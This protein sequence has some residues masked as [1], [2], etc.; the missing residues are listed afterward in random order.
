[1]GKWVILISAMILQVSV[2]GCSRDPAI[3]QNTGAKID[4]TLPKPET[5]SQAPQKPVVKTEL[6]VEPAE[7]KKPAVDPATAERGVTESITRQPAAS[8]AKSEKAKK[9]KSK[10]SAKQ[11]DPVTISQPRPP[12]KSNSGA[13]VSERVDAEPIAPPREDEKSYQAS[14]NPLHPSHKK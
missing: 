11:R 6:V 13:P 1:M 9:E 8:S 4:L 7:K 2:T 3:A 5:R 14:D 12:G 10:T